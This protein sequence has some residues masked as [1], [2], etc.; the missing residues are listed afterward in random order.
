MKK[1]FNLA[2]ILS[3]LFAGVAFTSCEDD[4]EDSK[5]N[6]AENPL[7]E[8]QVVKGGKYSADNVTVGKAF[9]FEVQSVEGSYLDGT[10]VV[11]LT[12]DGFN[13][14]LKLSDAGYSYLLWDGTQ[15]VTANT[16]TAKKNVKN[17]VAC[18]AYKNSKA[19]YTITSATIN[20]T[21]NSLGATE[22]LFSK[23][24]RKANK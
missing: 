5:E 15:F 14:E 21:M 3:T 16:E 19:D 12:I 7:P 24:N 20:D 18:L 13:G 11:V 17:I 23:N 1:I 8:I 4:E 2:V 10:Q 6:V 22:T 9:S